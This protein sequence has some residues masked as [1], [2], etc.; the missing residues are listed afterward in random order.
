MPFRACPHVHGHVALA[1]KAS[2]YG[3]QGGMLDRCLVPLPGTDLLLYFS[4]IVLLLLTD[5]R[6]QET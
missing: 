5:S 6:L 1:P 3:R 4:G 2:S